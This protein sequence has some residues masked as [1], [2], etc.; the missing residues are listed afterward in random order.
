MWNSLFRKIG[1]LRWYDKDAE[2]KMLIAIKGG[3]LMR[4]EKHIRSLVEKVAIRIAR[5]DANA[6]CPCISYQSQMPKAV[7]RLRKS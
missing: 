5:A 4:K 7:Q 3:W 1:N 6:A 2:N